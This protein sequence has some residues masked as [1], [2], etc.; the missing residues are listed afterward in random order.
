MMNALNRAK[1]V[2]ERIYH[3]PQLGQKRKRTE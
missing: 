1:V 3:D 2:I